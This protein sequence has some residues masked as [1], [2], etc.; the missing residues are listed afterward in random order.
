[1]RTIPTRNQSTTLNSWIKLMGVY[2]YW[3]PKPAAL[4]ASGPAVSPQLM[5]PKG[6]L[7]ICNLEKTNEPWV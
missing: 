5:R 7:T 1:M 6:P 3:R 4:F 2:N